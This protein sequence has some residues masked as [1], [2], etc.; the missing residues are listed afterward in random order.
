M[1]LLL[2]LLLFLLL[3]LIIIIIIVI[4]IIIIPGPPLQTSGPSECL[5]SLLWAW[6]LAPT[7]GRSG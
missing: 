6:L 5:L 4:I 2:L 7:G 1:T 3:L